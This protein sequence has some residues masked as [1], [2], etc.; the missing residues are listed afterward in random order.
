[1]LADLLSDL[2]HRLRAIFRRAE[3]E[4]ELDD[5]LRDHLERAAAANRDAG[6]PPDEAMRQ[7]RVA[8]GSVENAREESRDARGVRWIEIVWQDLRTA[9]RALR[10]QPGYT[11]IAALSL[12]VGISV[13][14]G[15]VSIF[16]GLHDRALAF[17]NADRVVALYDR[18]RP[19]RVGRF[20]SL[21]PA[22]VDAVA[23][24][25]LDF[26]GF[27]VYWNSSVTVRTADWATSKVA[28]FTTPSFFSILGVHAERGRLLTAADAFPG[29]PATAVIGHDF[30]V[31]HFGRDPGA[32]GR[33]V[34][35]N[36]KD[37]VIVGV[38]PRKASFPE[39]AA[40]WAV[41]SPG[42]APDDSTGSLRVIAGLKT[43]G[44]ATRANAEVGAITAADRRASHDSRRHT[45]L[46]AESLRGMLTDSL[47]DGL[48]VMGIFGIFVALIAS[49]N[50]AT[51]MLAR[52]MRRRDELAV[53]AALGASLPR[54]LSHML[55][56][57]V[58]VSLIGGVSGALAAPLVVRLV[59][60]FF[61]KLTPVWMSVAWGWRESLVGLGLAVALGVLF[62]TEPALELARPAVLEWSRAGASRSVGER[63]LRARRRTLVA[64]Q[65]FL[66]VA[67]I[68]FIAIGV[69]QGLRWGEAAAGYD[70]HDLY[71]GS[72]VLSGNGRTET[73]SRERA[74]LDAIRRAPGVESAAFSQAGIL[75]GP[76]V[77]VDTTIGSRS[78]AGDST[79][80]PV[81]LRAVTWN[82]V[83][84]G[85]FSVARITPIAGRL[86]TSEEIDRGAQVVV[87]TQSAALAMRGDD[88]IGWR[89]RI[90]GV[91]FTVIGVM[92]D[93][94]E[95]PKAARIAP[96]IFTAA[97]GHESRLGTVFI[98]AHPGTHR[99]APNVY[100]TLQAI[101]PA[102]TVTD[103]ESVEVA[104]ARASLERRQVLGF[105]GLVY[106][107][108]LGLAA[109]GVYGIM[110]YAAVS[111]RREIAVRVALG[112][113]R[114]STA[115]LVMREA[116]TQSTIG[117]VLGV[118]GG[119]L[120]S[121]YFLSE[122]GGPAPDIPPG[123]ILLIVGALAFVVLV[124][125]VVPV[126][127]AW[128][129]DTAT[130]LREDG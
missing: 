42:T 108:A 5:E 78:P 27:A 57:C 28:I 63:R 46:G 117:L 21:S 62:G 114:S 37:Y 30:W 95:D 22:S 125:S 24:R 15:V 127:R 115:L 72:V 128:C 13:S 96:A 52:G 11:A 41:Q 14:A 113:Q 129:L 119:I 67:P 48:L 45:L 26:T 61:P 87:V 4:R 3:V 9:A 6:L 17:P 60:S 7:A 32:I 56:E 31:G 35:I 2:A 99:L 55:T 77:G 86:L 88:R 103:L 33:S 44:A 85:Y 92:D 107:V 105:L 93:A 94:G 124:A 112:A 120:A 75:V 79:F 20:W 50:F 66:A 74:L 106:A 121:R 65:V 90:A 36:R 58:L 97:T 109:V 23:A 89:I 98:R 47:W 104:R 64:W 130:V 69:T 118:G 1:M 73:K 49:V 53:R 81:G 16:A 82:R 123:P 101:A 40:V 83:S 100:A 29:A 38:L 25:A 39:F 68:V 111:R 8:F 80:Q 71:S 70:T 12:A 91:D 122:L 54:L 84:S 59:A 116:A 110:S 34:T 10:A 126:R 102:L 51:L 76:L 43:P 18:T 19:S